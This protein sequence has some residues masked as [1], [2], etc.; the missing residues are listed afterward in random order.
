M[1]KQD[2]M[3]FAETL[4]TMLRFGKARKLFIVVDSVSID[5][6]LINEYWKLEKLNLPVMIAL[7]QCSH[8]LAH[9][10]I[11][12]PSVVDLTGTVTIVHFLSVLSQI[13]FLLF[14]WHTGSR[15]IVIRLNIGMKRK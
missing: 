4:A 11:V 7:L 15:Q 6:S 3:S 9:T 5:D 14:R 12:D 10:Y 13:N 2:T 8:T 1:A